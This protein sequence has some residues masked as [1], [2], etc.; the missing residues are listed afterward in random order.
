MADDWAPASFS[1][2]LSGG[3]KWDPTSP[4][5]DP[6]ACCTMFIVHKAELALLKGFHRA[7]GCAQLMLSLCVHWSGPIP[8]WQR[9]SQPHRH[10]FKPRA[11]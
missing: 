6:S 7:R 9:C 4:P 11:C 10:H 2:L 3:Q 5:L 1:P 8:C